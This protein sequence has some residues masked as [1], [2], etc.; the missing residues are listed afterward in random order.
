[1]RLEKRAKYPQPHSIKVKGAGNF[2]ELV[3]LHSITKYYHQIKYNKSKWR[4]RMYYS[5]D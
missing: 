4:K 2:N 5:K 3:L 1:M